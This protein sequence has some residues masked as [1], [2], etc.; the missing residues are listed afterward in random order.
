MTIAKTFCN[1]FAIFITKPANFILR[2]FVYIVEVVSNYNQNRT[3]NTPHPEFLTLVPRVEI[4]P[5]PAR[6]E[7]ANI[8]ISSILI[9]I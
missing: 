3:Q 4:H 1:N 6:G 7:G 5:S 8:Q 9:K 2:G